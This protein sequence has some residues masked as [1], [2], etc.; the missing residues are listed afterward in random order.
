M[1]VTVLTVL[2]GAFI[3]PFKLS[4]VERLRQINDKQDGKSK[5]I[6]ISERNGVLNDDEIVVLKSKISADALVDI[7]VSGSLLNAMKV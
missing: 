7:E 1:I 3:I 4:E 5:K 2:T 6:L